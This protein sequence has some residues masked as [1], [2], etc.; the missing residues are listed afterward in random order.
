MTMNNPQKYLV[1]RLKENAE[2]SDGKRYLPLRKGIADINIRARI[3]AERN[4]SFSEQLATVS[5]KTPVGKILEEITHK[6]SRS[7][8]KFRGLD[9]T[10]KDRELL[11]ALT[12]PAFNAGSITNK[13]LQEKL[14]GTEWAN[15]LTGKKLSSKIRHIS[16]LR[17]HGIIRKLPKQHKYVLTDKGRKISSA[18]N[19]LLSAST[20]DLVNLVA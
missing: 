20:E 3:S 16:L 8:K 13:S 7:G 2:E 17:S 14:K 4:K 19:A 10:G 15:G 12:D 6:I 18:L 11:I 9:V 5:D 1:Q